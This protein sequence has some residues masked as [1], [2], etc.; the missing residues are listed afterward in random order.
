MALAFFT[1]IIL[2]LI[3]VLLSCEVDK[4]KKLSTIEKKTHEDKIYKLSL[5]KELQEKIAYIK[6]VEK[7]TDILL[8]TLRNFFDYSVISAIVIK[9]D[10]LLFKAHLEEEVGNDYIKNIEKSMLSSLS[11]F[12]QSLPGKMEKRFYGIA[13]NDQIKITYS[14]SMHL[15][16]IVKNKTVALIHLSSAKENLYKDSDMENF[17]ELVKT[18]TSS[19]NQL[20]QTLDTE[21]DMSISLIKSIGD[22]VFMADKKNNLLLIN[23]SAKKILG[24]SEDYASF[25]EIVNIFSPSFHLGRTINEVLSN[26]KPFMAREVMVNNEK[27]LNILIVPIAKDKVSVVL[28]DVTDYKNK[29][30]LKEDLVNIMVHELR[31][32]I[33]TIKDSAELIISTKDTL[34]EDKKVKFL[35]IIH[36]QA[37]KLLG[38]I[39]SILDSAKLDA[40][41]LALQKSKENIVNLVKTEMQTFL[42][43]AERKNISLDLKVLNHPL[44]LIFLDPTRIAQ[45]I[46]NLLSNS[47]KF[48]NAGGKIKVEIDYKV[49]PPTLDGLS[50]MGDFLS[51]DKYIVVSVSDT[52]VGIAQAEQR[53]LFSKYTQASNT[54]EHSNDLGTGL[55]LYLV[56][57]II[58]SHGGRVWVKSAPGQG[59]T[60]SFTLPINDDAQNY[61]DE[62]KPSSRLHLSPQTLN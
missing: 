31:A 37:K 42:P 49:I 50:P 47:I 35:E 2:G 55:G 59:T 5:L 58:Q 51:L 24:L 17:Q 46:D 8:S 12:T 41:K 43:Q 32:P 11:D 33:T 19:L 60:I 14:S 15:P 39:G 20:N 28:H 38:R 54:P 57:G 29:E 30:I 4:L 36:Q 9:N 56:K 16:L 22:G 27:I 3:A 52:G 61:Y 40:G 53:L 7:V 6:D 18:I 62:P 45:V 25:L 1:T 26:N 34:Q 13:L 48:T 44:P 23:D 21:R 10:V